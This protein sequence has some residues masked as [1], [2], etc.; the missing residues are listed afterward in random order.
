MEIKSTSDLDQSGIN[1]LVYAHSG[2]GKTFAIST[3]PNP[4]I[5]SA[6]GGLL[7]IKDFGLPYI[8]VKDMDSLKAAYK[9]ANNDSQFNSIA[10]DSISEIAEVV[11]SDEKEK[12][13]DGRMAY[14]EL[15][16][17]MVSI[18]RGFR[19]MTR[20]NIYVTAKCEKSQ[21]ESGRMLYA[22]SMPGNKL[23]QQ[24]P[25]FFDEVLALRCEK[26]EEGQN[27]RFLQCQPDG[28]WAAKDRSGKLGMW[29]APDL[30]AIINKI[31]GA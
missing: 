24:L 2:A 27:V 26:N 7:S 11:L 29:E 8:E 3:L 10:I 30:G 21:D 12:A 28:L 14:A 19:D 25:Y 9:M 4:L 6:E 22:P 13:K 23:A 17:K 31:R 18:I 5:I 1:I 15:G 20:H 16:S